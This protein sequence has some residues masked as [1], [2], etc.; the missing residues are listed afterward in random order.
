MTRHVLPKKLVSVLS[1]IVL[2]L[3][4]SFAVSGCS[5]D[6]Q[7]IREGIDSEMSVFANPTS[8][9]L[10]EAFGDTEYASLNTELSMYGTSIDE[11]M[12]HV[13]AGMTY[14][15]G[16]ISID[17]D[18]ATAHVSVTMK[19]ASDIM[20]NVY[21]SSDDQEELQ[22]IYADQGITAVYTAVWQEFYKQLDA[23]TD[24]TTTDLDLTLTKTDDTWS[25]DDDSVDDFVNSLMANVG[26]SS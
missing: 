13:F 26:L 20:D 15:I 8:D 16:D 9:N 19:D 7:V 4:V 25:V 2:A 6:E 17:G 5:N 24:T 12:Q 14:Q 3:G 10:K 1:S 21:S 11:F 22:Q 23:T 18:K